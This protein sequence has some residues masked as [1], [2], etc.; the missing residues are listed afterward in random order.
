[1]FLFGDLFREKTGWLKGDDGFLALDSNGNGRIDDISELF[2]NRFEGGYA[3][4]ARYDSNGDGKIS[5]ADLIW[6]ELRVWQDY[7]RD[8]ITDT[9]ELKS[10]SA[11]GIREIS[12]IG[13]AHV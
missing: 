6:S 11:L 8:G 1:M 12:Q 3:E 4:L 2:G 9:G 5:Q 7:N 13:R 10:L